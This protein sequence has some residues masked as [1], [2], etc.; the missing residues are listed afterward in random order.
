MSYK[1]DVVTAK[2]TSVEFTPHPEGQFAAVCVDCIDMGERLKSFKGEDPYIANEVA[3]VFQTGEVNEAGR[4][5][6]VTKEMTLSMGKKANLRGFLESWRGKSYTEDEARKGIELHKLVG[7]PALISV[8]HK[9][10][11]AGR[12]Y[13]LIS[14]IAP[15]PKGLPAPELPDYTRPEFYADRIARN[16]EE[17]AKFKAING[18]VATA[19]T[20]VA[21]VEEEDDDLPF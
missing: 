11:Q 6:E 17:V 3:L 18:S 14:S 8:E 15:L 16:A 1:P 21:V 12:T 19:S 13:A 20:P 7:H 5:H 4:V 10:S 2:N 9:V